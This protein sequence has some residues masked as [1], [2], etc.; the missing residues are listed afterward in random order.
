MEPKNKIKIKKV[1][2]LKNFWFFVWDEKFSTT[3]FVKLS[4]G[5]FL[6]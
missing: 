1:E 5:F 6:L 3:L 4:L 2:K